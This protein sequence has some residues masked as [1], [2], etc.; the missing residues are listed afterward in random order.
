[1]HPAALTNLFAPRVIAGGSQ[2]L[3]A[4]TGRLGLAVYS[5][6]AAVGT[7]WDYDARRGSC[8]IVGR[9]SRNGA[10][11]TQGCVVAHILAAGLC[12][13]D[14]APFQAATAQQSATNAPVLPASAKLADV[15][16]RLVSGG[17]GGCLGR[18]IKYAVL[19]RGDGVVEYEDIGGEP[20]DPFQRRTIPIAEAVALLNEFV[21][22][23]FFEAPARYDHYRVARRDADS[24][25]FDRHSQSDGPEWDLTLRLG[26]QVK[27]VHLYIGFPV[28]FG[29]LRDLLVAIGGP[30]AWTTK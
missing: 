19:V 6:P 5:R 7:R 25:H 30:K 11:M 3:E 10:F 1:V 15:E 2:H 16:M 28:E 24:V 26:T 4:A 12:L 27:T 22:A 29:R 20:R 9:A 18:C 14:S 23:R 13:A 21:R 8:G 17:S